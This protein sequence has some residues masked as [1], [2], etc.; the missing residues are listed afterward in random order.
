MLIDVIMIRHTFCHLTTHSTTDSFTVDHTIYST[1]LFFGKAKK[2]IFIILNK[3]GNLRSRKYSVYATNE[4]F[5]KG[6]FLKF[7]VKNFL[8]EIWK[9][10]SIPQQGNVKIRIFV[11]EFEMKNFMLKF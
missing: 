9:K 1:W 10:L 5:E 4:K 11:F 2:V 7:E 8:F 6:H 3:F